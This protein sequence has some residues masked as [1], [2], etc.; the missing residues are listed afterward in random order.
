MSFI[1]IKKIAKFV[2]QIMLLWMIVFAYQLYIHD[3]MEK[4][5]ADLYK[6]L[7]A[8]KL[9]GSDT[10]MRDSLLLGGKRPDFITGT[11]SY[12]VTT[13]G[14]L[15]KD[16]YKRELEKEGWRETGYKIIK[17]RD[18]VHVS[19][20]F[21]FQKGERIIILTIK[22]SLNEYDKMEDVET[23]LKIARPRYN[24]YVDKERYRKIRPQSEAEK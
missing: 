20:E 4:G 2:A 13:N 1:V 14:R 6:Q 24:I 12:P 22:P 11:A 21:F 9:Y 16:Y 15:I 23:Y 19:D 17:N 10:L 18:E 3:D 7:P 5:K 8:I